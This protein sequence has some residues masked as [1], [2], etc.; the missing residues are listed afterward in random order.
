MKLS[1]A[2]KR[3]AKLRP[4]GFDQFFT[5]DESGMTEVPVWYSCALGAAAEAA[6]PD[7]IYRDDQ[8]GDEPDE[9]EADRT[10]QREFNDT[11][12]IETSCPVSSECRT[13]VV[14]DVISHLNDTHRWTR[15]A[16]SDW[17]ATLE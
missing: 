7:V 6:N 3:G 14:F 10:L 11:L 8:Y 13:A 16:I 1:E 17:V 4:Q 5:V 2:I 9:E 12:E 15:E